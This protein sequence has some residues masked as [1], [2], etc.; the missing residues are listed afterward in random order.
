MPEDVGEELWGEWWLPDTQERLPGRL[1]FDRAEG[2]RL[3]LLG[4]FSDL[5]PREWSRPAL[6]GQTFGGMAL[7]LVEPFWMDRPPPIQGFEPAHAKTV[8]GST[9]VMEDIHTATPNEFLISRAVVRVRGLRDLCLRPP[10]PLIGAAVSFVSGDGSSPEERTV[11][12]S[13]GSLRFVHTRY[14]TQARFTRTTHEDVEVEITSDGGMT[15][16][17]FEERWVAPLQSFVIFAGREPTL[18]ESLVVIHRDP[19]RVHP[20]IRRG[21]PAIDWDEVRINLLMPR[22]GL[23]ADAKFDYRRPLVPLAALGDDAVSFI[24]SWWEQYARLGPATELLMSAWGSRMFLEN[25]LLNEMSFA[26]SYHR[27]LHDDPPISDEE[28]GQHVEAMLEAV[29]EPTHRRHY[30]QRLLHAA[31]Q[32]QRQ[33]LKWLIRRAKQMLPEL[34]GLRGGLADALVNTRNALT[35]LDPSG[36]PRLRDEALYRAIE[37]LEV[38]LQANMLLDLGLSRKRAGGLL[39]TSYINQTP[40][41]PA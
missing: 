35:H 4:D 8:V 31:E 1:R 32:G 40:F 19:A 36:A 14:E 28:H 16:D 20:A 33:R 39:R 34:D 41:I 37:L 5:A 21:N 30:K 25:R 22:P 10:I 26:E 18:L 29:M 17:E 11:E 6:L 13:G 12:V 15:L 38:T 2:A 9:I 27:I 23:N 3:T 7:T 24:Q